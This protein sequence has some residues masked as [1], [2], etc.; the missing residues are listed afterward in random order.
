MQLEQPERPLVDGWKFRLVDDQVQGIHGLL[1]G[2]V[3]GDKRPDL[4]ANSAQ[5][6]APFPNSLVWYEAPTKGR[7]DDGWTRHVFAEGDAPGL[8]HYLG[9]G[10]VNGDGRADAASGAK[11]GPMAEPG[12]GDWFAW[13][14]APAETRHP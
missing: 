6:L 4:L 11:G 8:S 2:D 3:N 13:W 9:L 10:D 7:L 1:V 12:E 5:P 14:E